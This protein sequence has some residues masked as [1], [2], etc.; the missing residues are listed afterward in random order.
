MPVPAP[1][2]QDLKWWQLI[3]LILNGTKSTYLD[4]FFEPG[5]LIDTD[6]TLAGARGVCKGHYFHI[7]FC[8][9]IMQQAHIIAHLELLAFIV[10][11]KAWPHLISNTKFVVQLDNIVAVQATNTGHSNKPIH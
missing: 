6:A 2:L 5:T 9:F 3:M 8:Q 1:I 7:P 10:V 11:L 4:I